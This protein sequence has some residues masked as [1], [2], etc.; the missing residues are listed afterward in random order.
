MNKI[1]LKRIQYYVTL[2]VL[3]AILFIFLYKFLGVMAGEV[4]I[5]F[6]AIIS[7]KFRYMDV[8]I[9]GIMITM[10][11]VYTRI[12]FFSEHVKLQIAILNHITIIAVFLLVVYFVEKE[13][14]IKNQYIDIQEANLKLQELNKT[15]H[16]EIA[17][18]ASTEEAL[19]ESESQFRHAIEDSPVPA[20][21]Y[22][23]DGET[24]K[25]SKS[26][27]DITGYTIE[28]I[29]TMY[30]CLS[31]IYVL[32][33]D[34][35]RENK[36]NDLSLG[37]RQYNGEHHIRTREGDIRIWDSYSSCIG[38]LNDGRRLLFNVVIDI[39]ERKS[40]EALEKTIEQERKTLNELKEYDRIKT[41]FFANL[42]HEFRTPINVIFSAVQLQ[43]LNIKSSS[44][45]NV[46]TDSFKYTKIMKQNCYRILRLV[47]NLIDITKI[48]I[49]YLELNK[50]NENIVSLIENITLSVADYIEN[51]GLSLIFD[52]DVEEKIIVCDPEKIERIIMNLLANAVK[53]TPPG[54]NI[55]VNIE[56]GVENICVRVKDTGRGI[57]TEKLNCIFER[58]VQIDKSLTRDKEGSGIGLSLVK[59]LVELHGGTISVKSK[60]QEGTEFIVYIPC[61]LLESETYNETACCD[62]ISENCIEK[63]NIEFSDIYN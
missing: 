19:K 61:E 51:K 1:I 38:K 36:N 21:L 49:G 15:L 14:L 23:E 10:V 48:D 9:F 44:H 25:V 8:V 5:V 45:R 13:R 57:P 18:R 54:G 41:E 3:Y 55:M 42:S 43:E 58:F 7:Y 27:T 32:E 11:N 62:R 40:M 33:K 22:A 24:I 20:I 46:S 29:P 63:I 56:D 17:Q 53:F 35:L 47:N 16:Q 30:H 39:T 6:I 2:I 37:E 52:T 28:D 50:I 59:S 26:W 4:G 12:V 60:E 34:I 31:M